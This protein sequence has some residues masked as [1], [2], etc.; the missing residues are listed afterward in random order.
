MRYDFAVL[1][2]DAVDDEG[3]WN[4]REDDGSSIDE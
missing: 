3:R 2:D 4:V 1:N